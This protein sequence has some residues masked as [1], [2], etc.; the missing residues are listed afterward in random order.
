MKRRKTE[1][2]RPM[3]RKNT[4]WKQERKRLRHQS[5]NTFVPILKG[6]WLFLACHS[7]RDA[8]NIAVQKDLWCKAGP[9]KR[10]LTFC[11]ECHTLHCSVCRAFAKSADSL[12]FIS[13]RADGRRIVRGTWMEHWLTEYVFRPTFWRP[14]KSDIKSLLGSCL[15]GVEVRSCSESD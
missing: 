12:P 5:I 3:R 9:N 2:I 7:K 11:Q 4:R 15:K 8:N 1:D 14:T 6:L 13:G 10:W